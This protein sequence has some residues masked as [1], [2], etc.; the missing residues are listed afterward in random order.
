MLISCFLIQ[1]YLNGPNT[2]G[3]ANYWTKPFDGMV[4]LQAGFTCTWQHVFGEQQHHNYVENMPESYYQKSD[5]QH[6]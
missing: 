5:T 1:I 2:D 4:M 6:T 3:L